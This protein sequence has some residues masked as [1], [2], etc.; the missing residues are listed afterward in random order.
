MA[1]EGPP[2][3]EGKSCKDSSRWCALADNFLRNLS[4]V[5]GDVSPAFLPAAE[6]LLAGPQPQACEKSAHIASDE[7]MQAIGDGVL[8]LPDEQGLWKSLLATRWVRKVCRE[9]QG[10]TL[11]QG[12][13]LLTTLQSFVSIRIAQIHAACPPRFESHHMAE[14]ALKEAAVLLQA[15]STAEQLASMAAAG[16]PSQEGHNALQC[17]VEAVASLLAVPVVPPTLAST[18]RPTPGLLHQPAPSAAHSHAQTDMQFL[19]HGHGAAGHQVHVRRCAVAWLAAGLQAARAGGSGGWALL[20]RLPL[21]PAWACWDACEAGDA[22]AALQLQHAVSGPVLAAL[23]HHDGAL[24]Q[25][26]DLCLQ[27]HRAVAALPPRTAPDMDGAEALP[28]PTLGP[29]L[30]QLTCPTALLLHLAT[31][32]T[33]GGLVEC[34]L[35]DSGTGLA[36]LTCLLKLLA[37][38]AS[39]AQPDT[40]H[41]AV[42]GV[43]SALLQQA[44]A[45]PVAA[46]LK[47][48]SAVLALPALQA[49]TP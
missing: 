7:V 4:S 9:V 43:V 18:P 1:S 34:A 29:A 40:V 20:R 2:E 32:L 27:L 25:A 22:Q 31:G 26:A 15:S 44:P 33:P 49:H 10:T 19:L 46:L 16:S 12:Y 6:Q 24:W 13:T 47:R 3:G 23:R 11:G 8:Q 48:C 36:A 41:D 38:A 35:D 39:Q 5:Q 17:R 14:R 21:P 45:R 37:H 42:R 30:L 28:Q